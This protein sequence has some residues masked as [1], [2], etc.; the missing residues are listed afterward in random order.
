MQ[1]AHL[2]EILLIFRRLCRSQAYMESCGFEA[3][4]G[5]DGLLPASGSTVEIM[6]RGIRAIQADL[7]GQALPVWQ[8]LELPETLAFEQNAVAEHGDLHP[9]QAVVQHRKDVVQDE[10]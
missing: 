9:F 6:S 7:D 1:L 8:D 3:Y 2:R 5:V 4:N 10:W